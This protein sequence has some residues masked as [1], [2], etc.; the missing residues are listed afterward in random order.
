MTETNTYSKEFDPVTGCDQPEFVAGL[1]RK[2]IR[3]MREFQKSGRQKPKP[4]DVVKLR[5]KRTHHFAA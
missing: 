5:R 2:K 4:A 3:I 1:S